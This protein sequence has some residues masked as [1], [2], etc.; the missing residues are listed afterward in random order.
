M[1]VNGAVVK[2]ESENLRK[3]RTKMGLT[4]KLLYLD[5]FFK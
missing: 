4:K 3:I 5:F 1:N 2:R